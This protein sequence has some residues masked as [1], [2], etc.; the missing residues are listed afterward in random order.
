MGQA[1]L[2]VN[3]KRP[4]IIKIDLIASFPSPLI[5]SPTR[6]ENST[7][8]VQPDEFIGGR[9]GM[10]IGLLAIE[11]VSVGFPNL[12]QHGDAESEC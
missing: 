4:K 7:V 3:L 1:A 12:L 8:L 11:E 2:I 6:V 10:Q 5:A 9:D